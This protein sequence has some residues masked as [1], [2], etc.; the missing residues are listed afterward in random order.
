MNTFGHLSI[1]ELGQML[2]AGEVRCEAL[3]RAVLQD[4]EDRGAYLRAFAGTTAERALREAARAQHE[5]DA[6]FYRGPLHGI[7]Y[8]VKDVFDVTGEPNTAGTPLLGSHVAKADAAVVRRLAAAGAILVGRTHSGPLAATIVGINHAYGTPHNPWREDAYLPGGSSSGSAVAVAGGL[9]PF[10]LGTDTGGSV[11]VPAALC[12]VVGLKPT[13]ARVNVSGTWPLAPC[14][15]SIGPLARSVQDAA[16]VFAALQDAPLRVIKGVAGMRIG[17]CE[18]L[19]FDAAQAEVESA[20]REAVRLLGELGA[21]VQSVELPEVAELHALACKTSLIAADGYTIHR[22]RVDHP[23]SDWVVHWMRAA[24]AYSEGRVAH[25]R[26]QCSALAAKLTAR[27][28]DFDAILA[29]TTPV[30]A[31]PVSACDTPQSHAAMAASLS[32][33]TI[34]GNL[35]MWC[36]LSLPCGRTEDGLPIGL[37]VYAGAYHEANVIRVGQAFE[38]ATPW[39][40]AV[41]PGYP[42]ARPWPGVRI[43]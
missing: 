4:V 5:L 37:M 13:A 41:P 9:V 3:T 43:S 18:T 1:D 26:E 29:P 15:D 10:A 24:A 30:V 12:G 38:A 16:S 11:R 27:I 22:A 23:D 31:A 14:L 25:V 8:A 17:V 33:N 19:F 6:G 21:E 20:V 32:R 34:V 36:G 2:R 35:A 28:R 7:P 39:S 42:G 40:R